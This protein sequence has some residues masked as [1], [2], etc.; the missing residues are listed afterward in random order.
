[1]INREK[2][3]T[4]INNEFANLEIAI[5]GLQRSMEKCQP[6]LSKNNW[7][8]SESESIDSLIVKFA[9]ISDILTQKILTSIVILSLED[10]DGFID[11]VNICE[12]LKVIISAEDMKEIRELRN[13][14]NH[15]YVSDMI[16][17]IFHHVMQYT[18]ILLNNIT[19]TKQ[20]I[21]KNCY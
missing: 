1:M 5:I 18:P 20:Y 3:I 6:L 13:K 8:F 12:K 9:R 17:Q 21:V 14:V 11:K 16:A 15:E 2:L 19:Q 7:S 10:F 4:N